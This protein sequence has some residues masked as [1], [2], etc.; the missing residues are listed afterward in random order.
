MTVNP[1]AGILAAYESWRAALAIYNVPRDRD[2]NDVE[3]AAMDMICAQEGVIQQATAATPK[4]VEVQ[5][6]T[7]L[8]NS[9]SDQADN[10]AIQRG[11]LDYFVSKG[12][13]MDWHERLVVAAMASLRA[14]QKG[15]AA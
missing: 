4:G 8:E 1:D 5:L 11:D 6:W 9:T 2:D 13:D 3:R 15:A 14:M 10:E 12:G 7:F